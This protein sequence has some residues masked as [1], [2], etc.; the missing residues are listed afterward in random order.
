MWKFFLYPVY[1]PSSFLGYIFAYFNLGWKKSQKHLLEWKCRAMFKQLW[2]LK[3]S[4]TLFPVVNIAL[5]LLLYSQETVIDQ[6]TLNG[7]SHSLRLRVNSEDKNV[8]SASE[9]FG[10]LRVD[11]ERFHTYFLFL[12]FIYACMYVCIETRFFSHTIHPSKHPLPPFLQVHTPHSHLLWI[13]FPFSH[14]K[15]AVLQETTTNHD[16]TE[17]SKTRQK[18][19]HQPGYR[20]SSG[21][22]VSLEQARVRISPA[23]AIRSLEKSLS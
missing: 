15:R 9:M 11:F 7:V 18:P 4:L 20:N 21:G 23:P 14:S 8:K 16:K 19:S 10:F 12:L 2:G 1:S 13:H 6:L 22:K 5:G 3:G 17:Y